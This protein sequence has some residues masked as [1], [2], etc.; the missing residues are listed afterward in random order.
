[1]RRNCWFELRSEPHGATTTTALR[2]FYW[3]RSEHATRTGTPKDDR[4]YERYLMVAH[5]T[6]PLAEA[7]ILEI[8]AGSGRS[9]EL[10]SECRPLAKLFGTDLAQDCMRM[11]RTN[12]CPASSLVGDGLNLPF[13]DNSFDAVMCCEVLEHMPNVEETLEEVLR[14]LR[15]PGYLVVG[16][17]NHGSLWTPLEDFWRGNSR[18]G[19]G[20][21]ART[22][23]LAWWIRNLGLNVVK[24]M[25]RSHRFLYMD[26]ILD[27]EHCG[28]D[29]DAANYSCPLDLL[30]FLDAKGAKLL[31]TF[32]ELRFPR[33]GRFIPVEFTG[34]TVMAWKLPSDTT[35]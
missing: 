26:P 7:Y 32:H 27:D 1:M 33:F 8:G 20:V 2:K 29:S 6:L 16:T 17:P 30:R 21:H 9:L 18:K 14:V 19:M 12:N 34:S 11:M 35:R 3:D 13:S 10:V 4:Y 31:T 15:Q 28:G 25:R 22:D 5:E 24:R 23:A